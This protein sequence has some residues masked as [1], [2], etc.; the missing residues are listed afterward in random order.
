MQTLL[1]GIKPTG[2]PTLGTLLGAIIPF[3]SYQDRPDC[4]QYAFIA[5][6]H[7]LTL[8]Q[9][10][11]EL[12]ANTSLL[13]KTLIAS[14]L[15][16]AYLFRQSAISEH[17]SLEWILTCNTNI[18][19]LFKMPQY[20]K[21]CESHKNEAIPAGMFLYPS[22][23]NSDILLYDAD[24]IPIGQDQKPHI[25]LC[26][27]IAKRF[28]SRY[29]QVFTVPTPLIPKVG[30]KIMSLS[31]P[32]K[33][34]SKSESDKGTIYITDSKD[35][36]YSKFKKAVTDGEEQIYYNLETKPGISNLLTIYAAINNISIEESEKAFKNVPNYGILKEAVATSVWIVL[37]KLQ[38]EISQLYDS[39]IAYILNKG[40]IY[41]GTKAYCKLAEVY[42]KVGLR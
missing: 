31:D 11:E 33:K 15:T 5:D 42:K 30:A 28:N 6:L 21:Y 1:S 34:M 24:Y 3:V 2:V 7:A 32:T 12:K 20:K 26:I 39:Q 4:Q 18:A 9:D 13:I 17:N 38:Y 36:V 22:L 14:G 23:M 8:Y 37:E 25:D 35:V 10:P 27:D 41:A 40:E 29:G 16:K 19:E